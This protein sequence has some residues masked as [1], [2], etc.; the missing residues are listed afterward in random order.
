MSIISD[1]DTSLIPRFCSSGYTLS[2]TNLPD[3]I[4]TTVVVASEWF[5]RSP[6]VAIAE[7]NLMSSWDPPDDAQDG[8]DQLLSMLPNLTAPTVSFSADALENIEA[9]ATAGAAQSSD[10]MGSNMSSTERRLQ[11]N[12]VAQKRFRERQK[13]RPC[14]CISISITWASNCTWLLLQARSKEIEAQFAAT[15]AELEALKTKQKAL[16]AR[17][18]LLEKLVQFNKRQQQTG[19]DDSTQDQVYWSLTVSGIRNSP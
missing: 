7:M 3:N 12:K 15:T 4:V 10:A 9:A 19:L 17:N 1:A 8:F 2:L 14:T 18:L 13:V 16:E 11:K 5:V 6:V